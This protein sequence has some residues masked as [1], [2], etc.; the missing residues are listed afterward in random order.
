[1]DA[2]LTAFL[3]GFSTFFLSELANFQSASHARLDGT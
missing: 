1:M 3:A 2:K